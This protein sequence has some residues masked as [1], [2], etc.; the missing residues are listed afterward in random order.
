MKRKNNYSPFNSL[1]SKQLNLSDFNFK[2]IT[3]KSIEKIKEKHKNDLTSN[4]MINFI[5]LSNQYAKI[6]LN[7]YSHYYSNHLYTQPALFTILALKIYLKLTYREITNLINLSSEIKQYLHIKKAPH[8]TTIQKFFKKT[9]T[10]LLHDINKLILIENEINVDIIALDGSGFTNDHADKYYAKI[11]KKER[12]S[13]IKNHIAIDVDSRL[14]LNYQTQR[15]PKYDTEFALASIRKTKKYHPH[16]I[17]ADRA[18]DTE[19]IRKCIN[20]EINAFDQ[21]PVKKRAK[22]GKYR[23]NSQAIFRHTIYRRR[24]NVES[25]FSVIKRVFDGTNQSRTTQLANKETK[26]KNTLYN[27]YRTLQIN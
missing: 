6:C 21:I 2:K 4:P 15:G 22:N 5:I 16:Y 3:K 18:Y 9:Q 19:P 10:K 13:Y 17:L 1:T 24:N 8:Y 25:V 27:I 12:K 23:L 20:E 26:L 14:I 11:R 7:K